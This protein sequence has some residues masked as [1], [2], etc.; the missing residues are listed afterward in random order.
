MTLLD[1][2]D[3]IIRAAEAAG[4]QLTATEDAAFRM[5]MKAADALH[6]EIRVIEKKNTLSA[7]QGRWGD[8]NAFAGLLA[9]REGGRSWHSAERVTLSEDYVNAFH[10]YVRSNGQNNASAALYEGAGSSGGFVV[11]MVDPTRTLTWAS[12][13]VVKM[14]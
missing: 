8:G 4:R 6:A 5:S 14:F 11:P 3:N 1:K 9:N 10:D 12:V 13:S 7:F 2:G